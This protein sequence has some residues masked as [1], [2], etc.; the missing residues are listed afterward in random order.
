MIPVIPLFG[1][2]V[3]LLGSVVTSVGSFLVTRL[4]FDTAV[5]YTLVTGFLVASTALF[6]ALTI[7]I[8]TAVLAARVAMPNSLGAATFFLPGSIAQLFSLIVTVR[9]SA[10]VY[11][12]TVSTMAAYLPANPRQGLMR[13]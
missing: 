10:M 13:L 9:V 6:L 4:A 11:S 2:I 3:G 5:R 1:W 7:S 12:W 8:K